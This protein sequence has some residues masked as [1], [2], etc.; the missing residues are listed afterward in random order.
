MQVVLIFWWPFFFFYSSG[1]DLV[2]IRCRP[3]EMILKIK[4]TTVFHTIKWS[5]W[6]H[7][8]VG[9]NVIAYILFMDSPSLILISIRVFLIIFLFIFVFG[10][11]DGL[12]SL[13]FRFKTAF[14]IIPL[15]DQP[16]KF[17]YIPVSRFCSMLLLLTDDVDI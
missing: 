6:L 12:P 13:G 8:L 5:L 14:I 10:F 11:S 15:C 1:I 16:V 7:L 4:S 2:W 9:I 17:F 3:I